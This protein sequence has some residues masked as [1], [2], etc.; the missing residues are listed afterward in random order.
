MSL[1]SYLRA[2]L[3][4]P[5]S[6]TSSDISD[7]LRSHQQL[8]ADDLQRSGL[9]RDEAERR[10]R[11]EF[12][13]EVR[14]EEECHE[15]IPGHFF[16]ILVQDARFALRMFGKAPGFTVVAILTIAIGIGTNAVVFS[17]MN[18]LVLRPINVPDAGNLSMLEQSRDRSPQQSYPD[19]LDIRDRTRNFD[20]M[21]AYTI[22]R[23]GL[24][25]DGHSARAWL[26]E[27]SGN[28]FD[29]LRVQPYLG[30]FFHESDEH[31]PNSSPYIVLSYAY[32]KSHFQSDRGVVGRT[33]E[34]NTQPYTI[35]GVAPPGFN[36][37]E[38]FFAPDFWTPIVN[39][40]QVD[41]WSNLDGRAARGL[42]II[43]RVRPG[44]T[45]AQATADLNAVAS[46]LSKTY[47]KDDDQ[48]HFTLVRPGLLGDMLGKP[49]SAFLAGLMLLA[50]LILLAACANLGSLFAARASDRAGEIAL[51]LA[52][53]SSR[54]RILRQLFTE[55]VMLSLIG[56]IAGIGGGIVLLRWLNV[57]RPISDFPITLQVLPDFRVYFVAFVL[58]LFS[59]LIFGAIPVRQVL[60]SNPYEVVKAGF[61]GER[62]RRLTARNV[63]LVFQ[64]SACAVLVTA[65]LVAV[66]GLVRSLHSS[67]GFVP[68]N[69]LIA[70]TDL[71]MAG[72]N[73][74]TTPIMQKR[75]IET[76]ATVPGVSAV[77]MADRLP[78][79]LNGATAAVYKDDTVDFRASNSLGDASFYSISPNYFRAAGTAFLAGRDVAWQDNRDAVRVAVINR[80]FADKIFGSVDK[81]ISG[82]FKMNERRYEVIGVVED[83]KYQTLTEDP[84]FATFLPILQA[85]TSS[86]TLVV[87]TTRDP[88]QSA[89]EVDYTLRKLDSRLPFVIKT[90]PQ[91]LDSALFASRVAT[92]ALGILGALGAMLAITGIF[93]MASYAVSKRMRELAIRVALGAQKKQVAWAALGTPLRLLAIGS[94]I[95][96]VLGFAATGVLSYVVYQATPRDPLVLCGVVFTMSLLGLLATWIPARRALRSEPLQLL[97]EQ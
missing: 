82:H 80:R 74:D 57:W 71:D 21:I 75:L 27:A 65:S 20:G 66:R 64:I 52:L 89:P 5:F 56:G 26:Y 41:G 78:L 45:P 16:E 76:L 46:Y 7:E 85:P 95:G 15:E 50:S 90:W 54:R 47:P 73:E 53:G 28:Y 81:A 8:R 51:R 97:R 2:L 36:G 79:A 72:Y 93:G 4:R 87:R 22:S 29:V 67:L 49:V 35:L 68:E 88:A 55:S 1:F 19:Y 83:G 86:T 38:L 30:R 69:S 10:A 42:W 44:V 17:A 70:D 24:G 92:V 9:P 59:G 58:A 61:T 25:A 6:S 3:S 11:I 94:V 62:R 33:V 32:W 37:T 31:G 34:M 40:Q 39:Q 96:L 14:F 60:R 12:G 63:L 84:Q 43:G 91:Q 13:G 77:G 18:G 23:V 48:I